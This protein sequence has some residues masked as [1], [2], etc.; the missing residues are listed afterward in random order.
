MNHRRS[1]RHGPH[2]QKRK[3]KRQGLIAE[4]TR[5]LAS[6][7]KRLDKHEV[8]WDKTFSKKELAAQARVIK[9]RGPSL[10]T[11][12]SFARFSYRQTFHPCRQAIDN[13]C[14]R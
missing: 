13:S 9:F 5:L 14:R 7:S 4:Q 3:A 2:R 10:I 1:S 8:E 11:V 6:M 12:L